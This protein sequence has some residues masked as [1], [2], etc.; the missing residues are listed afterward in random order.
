[1]LVLSRKPG[2]QLRIGDDIT[3]TVKAV[4]GSRVVLDVE[5]PK[6]CR[7]L[8]GELKCFTDPGPRRPGSQEGGRAA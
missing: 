4:R 6:A 3:I 5:A 7:V 1:M 8:R 2:E